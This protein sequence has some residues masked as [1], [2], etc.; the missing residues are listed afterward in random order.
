MN[1]CTFVGRLTKDAQ[2]HQGQSAFCSTYTLA[3]DSGWGD[4]KETLFLPCIQFKTANLH[5]YLTKG[6]KVLVQG[7]L[8]EK[9][10]Q[11]DNGDEHRAIQLVVREMEFCESKQ[12]TE[13]PQQQ[14]QPSLQAGPKLTYGGA[15]QRSNYNEEV[16][17]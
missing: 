4:K 12:K 6:V 3:V 8:K 14:Y 17:F 9:K 13:P 10:W 5:V 2:D 7:H 16:P 1:S 15:I 11:D